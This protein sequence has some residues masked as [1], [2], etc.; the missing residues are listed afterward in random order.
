MRCGR[1]V[2]RRSSANHELA[3]QS[4]ARLW[5]RFAA[6]GSLHETFLLDSLV[7]GRGPSSCIRILGRVFGTGRASRAT[8]PGTIQFNS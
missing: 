7:C 5:G 3:Q 4:R 1:H 8:E 6:K 2:W